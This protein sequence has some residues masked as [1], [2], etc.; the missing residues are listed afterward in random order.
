MKLRKGD[1]V[2]VTSGRD[3]GKVGKVEK[4]LLKENKVFVSGVNI[5]KRH[6]KPRKQN[7]KGGII[8][9]VKPVPVA[10]ISFLCPKCKSTT[11]IGFRDSENKKVRICRKCEQEV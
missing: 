7:E 1:E 4:V 6:Y 9:I 2:K 11:R 5:Y 3:K 8:D 10:N